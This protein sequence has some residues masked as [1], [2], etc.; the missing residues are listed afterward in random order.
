M[1]CPMSV[2]VCCCPCLS[3][4]HID[5]YRLESPEQTA[6]L[7]LQRV[8]A[9]GQHAALQRSVQLSSS[10]IRVTCS[11]AVWCAAAADIS[12]VEW[13]ERL[14]LD[15]ALL[16]S[17]HVLQVRI[18]KTGGGGGQPARQWDEDGERLIRLEC[19]RD[20]DTLDA[21]LRRWRREGVPGVE[22]WEEAPQSWLKQTH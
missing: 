16:S 22:L 15:P 11:L 6:A 7:P 5:L 8:F 9:E 10:R 4:H 13:A 1:H 18:E 17:S 3:L 19:R 14:P 12:L 20:D 21:A 2:F